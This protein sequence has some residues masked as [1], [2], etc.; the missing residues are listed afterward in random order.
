[1]SPRCSSALHP[2]SAHAAAMLSVP[3]GGLLPDLSLYPA[4]VLLSVP[5]CLQAPCTLQGSRLYSSLH[6]Q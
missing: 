1:M 5:S 6:H 3:K 2:S 4:L